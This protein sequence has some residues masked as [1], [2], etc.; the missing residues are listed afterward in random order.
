MG[1]ALSDDGAWLALAQG[2]EA[3]DQ[4]GAFQDLALLDLRREG[5]GRDRLAYR[6]ALEGSVVYD[7]I[8]ISPGGR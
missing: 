8:A 7:G 1:L 5:S 4:A 6:F 3:G 2:R